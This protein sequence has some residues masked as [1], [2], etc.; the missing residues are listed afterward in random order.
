MNII[1]L[2]LKNQ[3]LNLFLVLICV[4]YTEGKNSLI[5]KKQQHVIWGIR[6]RESRNMY[7]KTTVIWGTRQRERRNKYIKSTRGQRPFSNHG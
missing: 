3:K 2:Y 5:I 1:D 6:Q 4:Q 7:N